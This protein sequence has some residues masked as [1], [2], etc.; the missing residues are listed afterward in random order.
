MNIQKHFIKSGNNKMQHTAR[1]VTFVTKNN[2]LGSA[3]NCNIRSFSASATPA[4]TPRTTLKKK[5]FYQL[6]PRY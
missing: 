2:V 5:Q 4:K 3:H 6:S 1:L